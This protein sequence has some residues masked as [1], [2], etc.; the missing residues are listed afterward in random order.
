MERLIRGNFRRSRELEVERAISRALKHG[1]F[2]VC[3]QPIYSIKKDRFESAEALIRLYDKKLGYISPDEFIPIAEKNGTILQIGLYV[4]DEVCRFIKKQ[5][6]QTYGIDYVEINL[7]VVQCMQR[8]LS[9]QLVRIMKYYQVRSEQINLEITESAVVE[10]P[11]RLK[12]NMRILCEEGIQFSLD[13][14]GSGYSNMNAVVS[15]PLSYVKLDRSIVWSAF[16]NSRAY[17]AMTSSIEMF[18][19]MNLKVI[20]EGIET[21][22]QSRRLSELGCDYLQGYYYSKP[23]PE[24]EFLQYLLKMNAV[25]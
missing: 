22:E 24:G 2:S 17:I 23:L 12:E 14:Y 8:E 9:K 3:Y 6:L 10:E 7:S 13:D 15:L 16:E 5:N 11:E 18:K 21:I 25:A 1:G 20:A 4:F 19:K